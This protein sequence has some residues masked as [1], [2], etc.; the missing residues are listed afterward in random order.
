MNMQI[1]VEHEGTTYIIEEAGQRFRCY[2]QSSDG[3]RVEIKNWQSIPKEA[4][5]KMWEA[6]RSLPEKE[7]PHPYD[8]SG[9]NPNFRTVNLDNCSACANAA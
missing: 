9:Y 1:P 7:K 6:V 3:Q 4:V 5:N 2:R 8:A